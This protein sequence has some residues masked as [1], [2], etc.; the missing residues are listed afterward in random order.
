MTL[1]VKTANTVDPATIM[2]EQNLICKSRLAAKYTLDDEGTPLQH[3]EQVLTR[4]NKCLTELKEIGNDT[5]EKTLALVKRRSL[6]VT[7]DIGDLRDSLED[8]VAERMSERQIEVV[9]MRNTT[10]IF[11]PSI[12]FFGMDWNSV[13]QHCFKMGIHVRI[14]KQKLM[15]NP[16]QVDVIL[17]ATIKEDLNRLETEVEQH[18]HAILSGYLSEEQL[19]KQ[20]A[21]QMHSRLVGEVVRTS[22]SKQLGEVAKTSSFREKSAGARRVKCRKTKTEN[23]VAALTTPIRM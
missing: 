2:C 3:V 15:H 7:T 14:F 22:S 11:D 8:A 18:A 20:L 19:A 16:H 21:R 9:D 23:L 1:T 10:N 5:N 4:L 13:F 17:L 12:Q 6:Q